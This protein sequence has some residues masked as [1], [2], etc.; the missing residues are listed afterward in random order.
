MR[1]RRIHTAG[2]SYFFTVNLAERHKTTL[3]D[4]APLLQSVI[5]AVREQ[6]P[7]TID[8]FVILPD[9]LHM[10]WTMPVNDGDFSTRW[11]LIKAG[12]S[13]Q[14]PKGERISSSRAQKGERGIWQRRFWEH[15]IR[16]DRDFES[17]VNYIHINP[18][19]HGYVECVKDWPHSSFHNY[20]E[21]GLLAEDWAGQPDHDLGAGE[22]KLT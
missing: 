10:M 13:R 11:A 17:H 21:R 7:F 14:L 18:V 9:H 3:V 22:A 12:F 8:A 20:V 15:Q 4:H 5:A 6:H 19:K 1:Y 2:A 16:D